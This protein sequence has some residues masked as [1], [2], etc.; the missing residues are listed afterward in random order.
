M[1]MLKWQNPPQVPWDPEIQSSGSVLK[2]VHQGTRVASLIPQSLTPGS[3][4][5]P[6]KDLR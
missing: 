2:K 4:A 3:R 1:D 5:A 6:L